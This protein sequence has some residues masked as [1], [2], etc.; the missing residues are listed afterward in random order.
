MALSLTNRL[1][2]SNHATS[3]HYRQGALDLLESGKIQITKAFKPTGFDVSS[4]DWT[5]DPI[6]SKSWRL[7]LH[8]LDWLHAIRYSA[9]MNGCMD[10]LHRGMDIIRDWWGFNEARTQ[11][12]TMAWDDH[13]TSNRLANLFLAHAVG[14]TRTGWFLVETNHCASCGRC[15][16]IFRKRTLD[17]YK[18][19]NFYIA[20]LVNVRIACPD[21]MAGTHTR[22]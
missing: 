11:P 20:S 21:V 4:I 15:E 18:S 22:I 7:Y 6:S 8:S 3:F 16:R 10:D 9:Q 5:M 14:G 1:W 17:P 19:C 13:A 2:M 12:E